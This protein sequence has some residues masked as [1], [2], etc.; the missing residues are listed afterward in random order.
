MSDAGD[1]A[2]G[3]YDQPL[4][5]DVLHAAGTAAEI[6]GLQRL[7]ERLGLDPAGPWLEPACGSGRCVRAAVARGVRIAGFD[8]SA[9]MIDYAQQRLEGADEGLYRLG[10]ATMEGFDAHALAPG[11]RFE[12]AFNPINTIRHLESD[13]AVL[14]HLERVRRALRPGGVYA[15]GL[16]M[17]VYGV[18]Q[19]SEDVW[20]GARGPLH[21]RQ[22]VQ[23]TPARGGRDRMEQVHNVLAVTRP[24]GSEIIPSHYELR[25]YDRAQ[26]DALIEASGFE[27]AGCADEA[28]APME[29]PAPG[30]PGYAVWLLRRA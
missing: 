2:R 22:V 27:L 18:E 30:A 26:W 23:Y 5:Y 6:D 20:E 24:G 8:A 29:P 21:V 19:P 11:W 4:L 12:L 25:S 15:V 10:V 1:I 9:E 7:C 17:S 28:G 13:R 16:S 14:D 3:F